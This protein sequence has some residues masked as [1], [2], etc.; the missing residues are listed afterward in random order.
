MEQ[1]CRC[2]HKPPLI[3]QDNLE[4]TEYRCS[5]GIRD[6]LIILL[7]I[8]SLGRHFV[9]Y[10]TRMCTIQVYDLLFPPA[11]DCRERSVCSG[12]R[13]LLS[14]NNIFALTE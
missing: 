7:Q 6:I 11:K 14:Q 2:L 3:L 12:L 5:K 8:A 10:L 9:E 4:G 13:H 1:G